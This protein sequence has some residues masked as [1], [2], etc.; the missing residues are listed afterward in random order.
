MM[1]LE[2]Y[3]ELT[4]MHYELQQSL[5]NGGGVEERRKLKEVNRK[6]GRISSFILGCNDPLIKE[7]LILRFTRFLSWEEI[8]RRI[9]GYNSAGS[10]RML[11]IRYINRENKKKF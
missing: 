8:A 2:N 11:V 5:A 3:G 4:A 6:L 10:C 7:L 9:G 1:E